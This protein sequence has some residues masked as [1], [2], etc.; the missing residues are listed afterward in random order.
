MHHTACLVIRGV[1]AGDKVV[2]VRVG[3]FVRVGAAGSKR[4]GWLGRAVDLWEDHA[5]TGWV[6]LDWLYHPEDVPGGRKLAHGRH[7]VLLSTHRDANPVL[8][9]TETVRV[10]TRGAWEQEAVRQGPCL[11]GSAGGDS[12]ARSSRHSP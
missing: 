3:D 4:S 6:A 2:R 10:L 9:I 5:G 7:E 11:P 1:R 8:S 12:E